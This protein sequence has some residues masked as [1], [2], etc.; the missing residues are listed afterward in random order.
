MDEFIRMLGPILGFMLI[1]VWIPLLSSATGA[2][3]D[4]LV[5]PQHRSAHVPATTSSSLAP[6]VHGQP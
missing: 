5:R 2:L 3:W 1:P 4:L 6:L